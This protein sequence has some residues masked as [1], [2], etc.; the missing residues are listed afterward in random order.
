[1]EYPTQREI[2]RGAITCRMA[3]TG[4]ARQLL[5]FSA[6]W[7]L[8]MAVAHSADLAGVVTDKNG[9]PRSGVVVDVLGPSKTYT[10]TD[11]TGNFVVHVSPGNYTVRVRDGNHHQ[12]FPQSVPVEG[13]HG[14][15]R[16]TW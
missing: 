16:L 13:V 9:T 10:Q 12:E 8:G 5:A 15:Y 1:M 11:G 3:R 14:N 6:L 4:Y 7:L 2:R